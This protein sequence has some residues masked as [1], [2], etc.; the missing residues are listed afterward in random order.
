MLPFLKILKT[1]KFWLRTVVGLIVL[2][3]LF[4]LLKKPL[5][6]LWAKIPFNKP[7][8]YS[9][10]LNNN[11]VY[12]GHIKSINSTTIVLTDV[13]YFESY[14]SP[15]SS[16]S[17]GQDLQVQTQPQKIY[18]FTKRGVVSPMLTDG[19]M[20]INRASVLFWERL[21]ANSDLSKWI[22]QGTQK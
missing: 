14:D 1:K 21:S 18:N 3:A 22:S 7:V 10:Q 9:V 5:T 17:T 12:F 11:Q 16:L 20:Y 8:Y 13:F 4:V 15:A 2:A 6:G 19:Q